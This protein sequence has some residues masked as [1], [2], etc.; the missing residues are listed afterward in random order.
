MATAHNKF[1]GQG[2]LRRAWKRVQNRN[3]EDYEVEIWQA[4][5]RIGGRQHETSYSIHRHGSAKAK[6]LAQEWLNQKRSAKAELRAELEA[7]LA[8]EKR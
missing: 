5:I 8:R 1:T 2:G 4:Y 3:G 6:S 7:Q